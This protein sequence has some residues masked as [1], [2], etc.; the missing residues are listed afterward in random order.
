MKIALDW[1]DTFTR[2][3]KFWAAFAYQAKLKGHEV[4]IVTF[5][6]EAGVPEIEHTL[7]H[8]HIFIPVIATNYIQKRSACNALGWLP[9]VWIDD[10]PEFIVE[11]NQHSSS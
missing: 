1:D 5:R 10:S 8:L 3:P 4:R 11:N 9:D 2:D 7:R 6:P